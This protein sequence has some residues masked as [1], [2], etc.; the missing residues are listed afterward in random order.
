VTSRSPPAQPRRRARRKE[1]RPGEIL[2]A[3]LALFAQHGF[4]ATRLEDVAHRAGVS[5]GTIYLYF[6]TKEALFRAVVRQ[7]LV[8]NIAAME[9]LAATHTGSATAL[10]GEI[11]ARM[12]SLIESDLA[13]IP[14]LV[15]TE[16]GNFPSLARFYAEEVA[17]RGRRLIAGVIARGVEQGEFRPLDIQSAVPLFIAP[18][19]LLLLWRTTF[20]RHGVVPLDPEAI[21]RTHLEVLARGFAP[22]ER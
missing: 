6:P 22:N 8:P 21:L 13:V 4:A 12:L 5:K 20:A 16:C 11:A 14:K 3:A 10:L 18:I 9:V 19:L 17:G 7:G 2:A 15:L 1:A